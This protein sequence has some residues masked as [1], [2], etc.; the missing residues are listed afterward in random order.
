MKSRA[1]VALAVLVLVG[2]S[3]GGTST[4]GVAGP[5][6]DTAPALTGALLQYR[7][8]VELGVVQVKLRVPDGASPL[9]VVGLELD[10]AAFP[11]AVPLEREVAM[12]A[13]RAVDLPV[14]HGAPDCAAEPAPSSARVRLAGR[15]EL[16]VVPLADPRDRLAGAAER[17]CRAEAVTAV[18]PAAW[19]PG[20]TTTATATGA[21]AEVVLH[22]GPVAAGHRVRVESLAP[23]PLFSLALADPSALPAELGP[24]EFR[25]V[26]VRWE[27]A[28]CDP[29]AVAEDKRGFAPVL[30]VALDGEEAA[31]VLQWVP[32]EQ[33]A[34]AT[35][36]LLDRCGLA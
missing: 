2:C 5:G 7:R 15:S 11:D 3:S 17:V 35:A 9:T 16:L 28:R 36:V 4:S 13:G 22:L 10:A 32:Q 19:G 23:T 34:T 21:A 26:V 12:A 27:P 31:P 25:D 18:L 20:W 8:D 24:G 14:V 33:R 6:D 1:V 30:A 29:H